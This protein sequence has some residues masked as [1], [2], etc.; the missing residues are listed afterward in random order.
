MLCANDQEFLRYLF[1]ALAGRRSGIVI[2]QARNQQDVNVGA[3]MELIASR[4]FG[5]QSHF[6]GHLN[7]DDV[8][9][10]SLRNRR[11]LTIDFPQAILSH[12]LN[13]IASR[14]LNL[15]GL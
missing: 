7:F 5:F 9:W 13:D 1:A 11:L 15:F 4:Y 2:N 12:R 6:L 3:S 10:K 8:A 14:A